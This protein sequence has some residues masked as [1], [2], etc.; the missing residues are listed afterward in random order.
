MFLVL[1][2]SKLSDFILK[3]KTALG[4]GK[5]DILAVDNSALTELAE[6]VSC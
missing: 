1:L 6:M 3:L 5:G 2:Y 4:Q